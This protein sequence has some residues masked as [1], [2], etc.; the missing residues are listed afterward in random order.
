ML[1]YQFKNY[2][3]FKEI[4]A[5]E[6]RNNGTEVRKNKILLSHLKNADL[7]RFC[8]ERNDFTL[9]NIKDMAQLQQVVTDA[10]C[11][12]GKQDD[13]L[14]HR[15][16]LI[17]C[18]YWSAQYRTDEA[19]GICEDG[20]HGSI[21]YVNMERSRVFKMKSAKFLRAVM[22]ETIVG[23]IL[24]SS[25]VNWLCGDVFAKQWYTFTL[26]C[27]SG[28][29]LHVDNNFE[30]IYESFWCKGY[31]NSCMTDMDR[32]SFYLDSV[33]AKAAYLKDEEGKI[34]AR[35]IL[36]TEVTDQ[37][38]RRWRLLERQYTTG[39]DEMLKYMLVNK[40]IQEGYIDGYKIVGASCH[41]A[42]AFVGIDGSSLFDRKFEIDCDLAMDDTLSYQDSFKWYDYE[43][44]KAYNYKHSADDYLLDT[45]DRNLNGDDDESEEA[46]D[47]YNQRYCT[48]TQVC[49]MEGREIEVDVDDLEDF[50]Y[51]SSCGE[52]HH[53]D[54][55][56]F[57]DWCESYCLTGDSV[58]SEITEEYYCCEQCREDA[59][60]CHKENYWHYSEYDKDWF[61]DA[62]ELTEIQI[63][64]QQEKAYKS[65]TIHLNTIETLLEDGFIVCFDEE[66]YDSL[67]SRTG[68]PFNFSDNN[69]NIYEEEHEYAAVEEAI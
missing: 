11:S 8:H 1:Y 33:K 6:K 41:E 44:R 22:L 35:A 59:E 50:R 49:Y 21:R 34:V 47:E 61:E 16:E 36:F 17:G 13:S 24:S 69:I 2:D 38:N 52:Y 20:D 39:E 27:T 53:H 63:W 58:Y 68:L 14:P 15:V 25:V 30:A 45:T 51:I 12:S 5:V 29:E 60:N 19:R 43:E 28:M 31:F 7:L 3:E 64:N 9:L 18:I 57:C 66:Y 42:N 4:F 10:V 67:D 32:H 48:E 46:W 65:Q 56:V 26:G 55:T 54:D 62:D 40:L 37:D 23:K